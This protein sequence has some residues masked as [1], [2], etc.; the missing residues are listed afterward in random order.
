[1]GKG[2]KT[3]KT[4]D[5]KLYKNRNHIPSIKTK[6]DDDN[7][8][9]EVDRHHNEREKE[10]LSLSELPEDVVDDDGYADKEAVL[11]LGVDASDSESEEEFD[12]EAEEQAEDND[13]DEETPEASSD[14]DDV[15]DEMEND[16]VMDWGKR[17]SSYFGGDTADLE[18]GQD[19]EDAFL[20]EEAAKEVQKERFKDMDEDDFMLSDIEDN[21]AVDSD[22]NET[23]RLTASRDF[24]SLPKSTRRKL[25]Q[26]GH[27]EFLPLIN[28]FSSSVRDWGD[29]TRIVADA[30]FWSKDV[31]PKVRT[32]ALSE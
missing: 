30:L 20:E 17:Q 1:M 6:I 4:G 8:Y 27:P 3:A 26:S 24:K 10:F 19:E 22:K 28:H 29:R 21:P 16:D 9:D 2:R 23:Q 7:M 15:D 14:E 32:I 31:S 25:L 5:K 12:S 18:I 11:D 13:S